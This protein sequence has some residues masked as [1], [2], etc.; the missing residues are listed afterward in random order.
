MLVVGSLAAALV[1]AL[2]GLTGAATQ[3]APITRSPAVVAL[4]DQ[5]AAILA[6][7]R[8][9]GSEDGLTVVNGDTGATLYDANGSRRLLPASN[10]KLLTST[11][12]MDVLGPDFTFATEVLTSG[13]RTHGTIQGNLYLKGFGD[14]MATAADYDRLAADVARSGIRTVRGNLVADDTYFDDVR[15]A[16]FWSWDDEPYYYDAQTSALNVSPDDI[17]DTGTVLVN[18]YPG[19]RAGARPRIAMIPANSYLHVNVTATTGPAGSAE[20]IDAVR[21]HGRNVVDVTGSIPLGATA[22]AAQP[23]VD[24][25]TGLVAQLFA[26][27]LR[28]HGVHVEGRHTQYAATPDDAVA[29]ATHRSAPLSQLLT[30]FLKLSNNMMAEALTKAMGAKVSGEGSWSA[31]TDA[32]VDDVATNG[33]DPKV[34]QL[35]DGSGLGRADYLTTDQLAALLTTV[36]SKPWFATWYAALPIAGNPDQLIGGTLRNRMRG[37]AAANNLHGKTGSMTGVSALSGYVT[38]AAGDHL[39]F[40]MISNNFVQG[41]ITAIED[42]VAETLANYGGGNAAQAVTP[43]HTSKQ[44]NGPRAQLECSWTRSC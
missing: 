19:A 8:L 35:F 34:I 16:P 1:A 41:G 42:A 43:A 14:P 25:P 40:S 32:I 3:A 4:G 17:G 26:H 33:V 2:T 11:A 29:I 36:R 27:D 12:A 13:R 21:E 6:D 24:E 44:A 15:L 10:A 31:G 5:L 39:V 28:A 9:A 23:T 20:T 22:Y 37:T 38:D 7:P 18:V 30:P